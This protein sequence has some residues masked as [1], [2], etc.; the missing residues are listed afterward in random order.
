MSLCPPP[1][2]PASTAGQA[3]RGDDRGDTAGRQVA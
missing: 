3:G 1:R 2:S